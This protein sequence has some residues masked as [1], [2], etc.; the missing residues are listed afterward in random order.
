[1]IEFIYEHRDLIGITLGLFVFLWMLCK[2]DPLKR[3]E[4]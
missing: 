2:I 1:M 3:K 4:D